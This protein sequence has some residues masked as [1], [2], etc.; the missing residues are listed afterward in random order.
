MS[1][2]IKLLIF[3]CIDIYIFLHFGKLFGFV[4]LG[5]IIYRALNI[6]GI[7][8]SPQIFR[9]AFNEGVAYL[10]DYQGSFHNPEA[11][12]E[13]LYLIKTYKLK[14]FVVIGIFYDKPGEV[15]ENKLRSSIGIYKKNVGFAD[16][17]PKEFESYCQ[18]N[19]YYYSEFPNTTCLYSSWE[20]SNF[21]TMM[22]GITKFY[23]IMKKNLEDAVFRKM[24][25]IKENPK[26]TIE[27]YTSESKMEFHIPI[28]NEDKF[29][30][31]K[32]ED[33]PKSE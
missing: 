31:Y 15:P 30:V 4:G 23:S 32:K 11:Y 12:K 29:F 3:L 27:L 13:A 26:V 14:D 1:P 10:K 8:R 28:V 17:V 21:F 33:K 7:L 5:I 6:L 22:L 2:F 9:G 19:N 24:Y 16:P 25:K 20:Y 18:T